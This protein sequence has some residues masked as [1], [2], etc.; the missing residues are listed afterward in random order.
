M[1]DHF[2]IVKGCLNLGD[3]L[4]YEVEDPPIFK[5]V[6]SKYPCPYCQNHII[7]LNFAYGNTGNQ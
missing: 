6:N 1:C 5:V 4:F 7:P 3:M 2:F